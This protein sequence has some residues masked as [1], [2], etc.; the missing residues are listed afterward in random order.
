[1]LEVYVPEAGMHLVGWLPPHVDGAAVA[2]QAAK[3]GV[4]VI[5]VAGFRREPMPR[6]GLVLG[7]A[8]VNG[9]EIRDGVHRLALA[10][11]SMPH[12]IRSAAEIRDPGN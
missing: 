8:A 10:I 5:P 1:M 9:Q 6:E 2:Q 3:Y 12:P 7:Y 11:R 4:E